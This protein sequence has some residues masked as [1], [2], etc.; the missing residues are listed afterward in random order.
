M[1]EKRS[2]PKD[3]SRVL[4]GLEHEETQKRNVNERE[5]E[6]QGEGVD[7]ERPGVVLWLNNSLGIRGNHDHNER[8]ERRRGRVGTVN[9]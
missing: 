8:N 5:D 9:R 7:Q 3:I 6:R 1:T 4:H 2:D